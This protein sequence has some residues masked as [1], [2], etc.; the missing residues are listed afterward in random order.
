VEPRESLVPEWGLRFLF[1]FEEVTLEGILLKVKDFK[2]E[3][4][5]LLK[6][7]W[8][9]FLWTS[10]LLIF[11]IGLGLSLPEQN[12]FIKMITQSTFHKLMELKKWY[13]QAPLLGKIAIIWGNNIFAST[14]AVIFGIILFPPVVSLIENGMIL[15]ILQKLLGVKNGVAPVWFYLSLAPHGI[16]ELPA[17]IMASALGIK[18]GLIPLR[19]MYNQLRKRSHQPLFREFFRDLRYYAV[20]ILLML[21]V[22]AIIEVMVSPLLVKSLGTKMLGI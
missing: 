1:L 5:R 13:L 3:L 7:D 19:L 6:R 9:F 16:F 10:W 15:G 2:K 22:A 18:F 4:I 20:L 17:F 21:F 14:F 11:G 8:R 12:P